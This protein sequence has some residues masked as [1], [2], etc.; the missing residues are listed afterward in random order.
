MVKDKDQIRFLL[1]FSIKGF[2]PEPRDGCFWKVLFCREKVKNKEW[3]T[4][5]CDTDEETKRCCDHECSKI[6]NDWSNRILE[7][8]HHN[9]LFSDNTFFLFFLLSIVLTNYIL[10]IF[11]CTTYLP[12]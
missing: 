9:S 5:D 3:N 10:T 8:T 7:K 2:K 6:I 4:I 1:I 12:G 11:R